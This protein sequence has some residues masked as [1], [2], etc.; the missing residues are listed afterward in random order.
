[1]R[2]FPSLLLAVPDRRRTASRIGP[3]Q[4]SEAFLCALALRRIRDTAVRRPHFAASGNP[5]SP[6]PIVDWSL[7]AVLV[8]RNPLL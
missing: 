7:T 6:D 4:I 5:V 3:P 8:G 2:P 1:M